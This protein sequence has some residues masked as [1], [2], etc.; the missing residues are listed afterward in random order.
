MSQISRKNHSLF[1]IL[2]FFLKKKKKPTL[3][4][5]QPTTPMGSQ[6]TTYEVGG[7]ATTSRA[8]G[9]GQW[10]VAHPLIFKKINK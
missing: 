8:F 10:V 7:D 6:T 5:G 9:G 4:S 3:H 1:F 2:A